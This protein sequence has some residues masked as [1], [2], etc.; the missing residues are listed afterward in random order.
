MPRKGQPHCSVQTEFVFQIFSNCGSL[1]P[2]TLNLLIQR[3]NCIPPKYIWKTVSH[4]LARVHS[5]IH[6]HIQIHLVTSTSSPTQSANPV[7]TAPISTHSHTSTLTK[8]SLSCT[9]LPTPGS[10][11]YSCTDRNSHI[12]LQ[13][14][15]TFR[16]AQTHTHTHP[17]SR[18]TRT[19]NTFILRIQ[20]LLRMAVRTCHPNIQEA[21]AGGSP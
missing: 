6:T 12:L 9:D 13:H 8:R 5:H 4:T 17:Q 1:S 19:L 15:S 21:E 16:F 11:L 14:T 18:G 2:V 7:H 20:T 3:A 10:P